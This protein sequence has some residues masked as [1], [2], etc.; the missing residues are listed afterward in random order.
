MSNRITSYLRTYVPKA[1]GYLLGLLL[2]WLGAHAPWALELLDFLGLDLGNPVVVAFVVTA[3]VGATE[4]AYYWAMRRLE[5]RLPDWLTRALLG[6]AKAPIY[7]ANFPVAKYATDDRVMLTDGALVTIG[8]TI[9]EPDAKVPSY[10]ATYPSGQQAE[11]RETDI[12]GKH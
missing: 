12:V 1:Y 10:T 9:M 6:S 7:L 8:A 4:A 5:P 11:V 2:A 3:V